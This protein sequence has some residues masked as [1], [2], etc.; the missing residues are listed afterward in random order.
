MLAL[1]YFVWESR[2]EKG[3]DSFSQDIPGQISEA[4]DEKRSLTPDESTSTLTIAD[5]SIAV[6][7]F[8]NRSNV[9]EDLFFTDGIHDDLL[10]Q[11]AKIND[12]KVISRTSVMEYR[13]TTKKIREIAA[14]LGVSKILEGG[15]QRAGKRIRINAQLIDV[16]TDEHLWAE[17]FDREMTVENI[18]DIQSEIT[19]H[20]VTAIRGE[21]TDEETATLAQR[22]TDNLDAYEA[23][24]KARVFLSDPLYSQEKYINAEEWLEKAVAYDPGFAQAWSLL[25]VTHGQAI[26]LGYDD[27]PERLQAA[28]NA[29]NN[30]EKFGPGLPETIAAKA[31]YLYRIKGDF[32]AA[33][34]LF[35]QAS[36]ANPGDSNLL[37]KLATTER[38]TGQFEQA[39][40]HFQMAIDL[41]PAN[42]DARSV[43]L[44]TLLNMGAYERAE[45][46]ADLWIEKYPET[47]IFKTY[48]AGILT[49][50]YGR[51][52][53]AKALMT[54]VDP[55]LG[56][57]YFVTTQIHFYLI[58]ITRV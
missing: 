19:R 7:P 28:L 21:L 54:E 32:H 4:G 29:L 42:L 40:T 3:S 9:Q 47:Q 45:P 48:K 5:N 17:T 15:I 50:A 41:D 20:I 11:L 30:A 6:L 31:E 52:N 14:E 27:S 10:T 25:V 58:V 46:L 26:W 34:P 1:A 38:R 13:D 2:F 36:E 12:L 56:Y 33:E 24:L 23:Y 49:F 57:Q 43:L 44:D 8:A 22:P 18:F 35:A 16:N 51:L 39:I 37:M 55:N 53:E